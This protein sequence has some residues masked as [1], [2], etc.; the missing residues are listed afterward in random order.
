MVHT[1]AALTSTGEIMQ[2]SYSILKIND[3]PS[4]HLQPPSHTNHTRA[5]IALC[6]AVLSVSYMLISVFPYSG[7][8]VIQLMSSSQQHPNKVNEENVG[9]YAGMMASS[10]MIGRA[11]SSYGWGKAADI[12]GRLPCLSISLLLS[13]LLSLGFGFSTTFWGALSWRFWLGIVNGVLPISKTSV[14]E[15]AYGDRT[16]ETRGMGLVM[17]MWGWGFLISPA[18]SG[19][20]AEPLKQYP[21]VLWLQQD[22]STWYYK[23]LQKF[24]FLLP[25]FIGTMLG[26]FALLAVQLF[27]PETLP[28]DSVLSLNEIPGRLWSTLRRALSVIPE[29]TSSQ[30]EESVSLASRS[31]DES[32]TIDDRRKAYGS[33]RNDGPEDDNSYEK[34]LE[35][36]FPDLDDDVDDAVTKARA[37]Y[38]EYSLLLS[39][40][41][42]SRRSITTSV[43]RHS[44]RMSQRIRHGRLS[45]WKAS[46][47]LEGK[48]PDSTASISSL[49]SQRNTRNHM[50][51]FWLSSFVSTTVDEG[52]PLFCI[53]RAGGLGLSEKTIGKILS[54][55]GLIFALS[56]YFV[57]TSLVSSLGLY[58]SIRLSS[59]I[60]GPMIALIPIS[61]WINRV[62]G[63]ENREGTDLISTSTFIFLR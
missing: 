2:P 31:Y 50:I 39:T 36:M 63:Q 59:T 1:K 6:V 42:D 11:I 52:F 57:F 27:V 18:I 20:T 45:A 22:V 55:C 12:Y 32:I 43:R 14:S 48:S 61:V 46:V 17:G 10:F 30:L 56:Q 8:M 19:I 53:S 7:Y 29:E 34:E 51:I 40:T 24:P 60:M 3:G 23:I 16:L 54:L 58:G 35:R 5:T 44:T 26:L 15:L 21:H 49:W 4:P 47:R 37:S 41:R 33:T 25:N 28:R 9:F 62:N 38:D 13:S